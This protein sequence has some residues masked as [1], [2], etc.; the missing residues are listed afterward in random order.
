[1]YGAKAAVLA[2]PAI[3]GP[4]QTTTLWT[5]PIEPTPPRP[6]R[7]STVAIEPPPSARC[8]PPPPHAPP[9]RTYAAVILWTVLG[10]LCGCDDE[11]AQA[12][13]RVRVRLPDPAGRCFG[14]HRQGPCWVGVVLH[15]TSQRILQ[16]EQ[17]LIAAAGRRDGTVVHGSTVELA[18]LELAANGTT[19][20]TG[21]AALVRGM[22]T[23][24]AR[25]Q[26][27]IAPAGAGKTTAMRALASAWTQD[28]GLVIGLAT[29]HRRSSRRR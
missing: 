3:P 5:N 2:L 21:Q 13:C 10:D 4:Q 15:R 18:L 9:E 12:D 22:C 14:R 17:R 16:A 7:G 19:L 8:T 24:G 11:P 26:L 23:S 1:M 28:G 25:L 27:A 29:R 6:L 20:D